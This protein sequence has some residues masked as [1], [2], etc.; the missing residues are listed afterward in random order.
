MKKMS[1]SSL[2]LLGLCIAFSMV[3]SFVESQ[4][5]PL[6]AIPGIK[7]GMANI[8]VVFILYRMGRKQAA[9]VSVIRVILSSILF[10]QAASFL[11]SLAGA[12]LSLA[13]MI[14]LKRTDRFSSVAVS[15]AGGV[16][17]NVG[18]IIV[19]CLITETKQLLLYLPVLMITGT[20]SGIVVGLTA[21]LLNKRIERIKI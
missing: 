15:V 9:L 7:V 3:L 16:L 21:G 4:L 6:T 20:V 13:G 17:H 18:Q 11:Y 19:A 5:P 10:G 2:V 14:L 12:S 1:V 8:A